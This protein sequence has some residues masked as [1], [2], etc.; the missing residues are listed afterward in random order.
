MEW[1]DKMNSALDYIEENLDKEIDYEV[2]AMKACCSSYNF[3][4]MFSFIADVSLGEYIRRRKLTKAAL[5]LQKEGSRV[6][7]VAL[8]Y[9]YES[10]V[11]FARAFT[12]LHGVTPSEGKKEGATLKSYPRI[13]FK[14]S[15]KGVEEMNYRIE[16]EKGFRLLGRKKTIS[17]KNGENFI[18][19][20]KF[21]N[22][23]CED[24]TCDKL[25][26]LCDDSN[27]AMY[28]VCYNFGKDEFDYM[29]AVNSNKDVEEKYEVLDVP[30]LTWVKFECRGKMPEAQQNVW[31]R[32]FTEWLPTS[33]YEHDEGPEIEW[34]SNGD[35]SS[36]N[37]LSEIW[38]PIKKSNK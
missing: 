16:K 23:S 8:K 1:I 5:E 4:R 29:I 27:K 6:L 13:S 2:V 15:I 7:D 25:M 11:S 19:I 34:Y 32:I 31:K 35:M 38:I 24:G 14:I 33:G 28:G 21:W 30:E 37:Y 36:D 9:G 17:T 26:G 3:Q 10:P 20:P 18:Q 12:N 22:E